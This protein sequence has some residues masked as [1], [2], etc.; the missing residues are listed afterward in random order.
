MYIAISDAN[1]LTN[2]YIPFTESPTFIENIL[3]PQIVPGGTTA[4]F[5]CI[6]RGS[7]LPQIAW[8]HRGNA[9]DEE[10]DKY[11]ISEGED[12]S[13]ATK[14]STLIIRSP[15]TGASG[16]VKCIASV[17]L[18]ADTGPFSFE[19]SS[20]ATHLTV[21]GNTITIIVFYVLD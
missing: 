21:L 16:E 1:Q 20:S 7:P 18:D 3:N 5:N 9:V 19:P 13:N 17:P 11:M 2:E 12:N 15:D 6:V 10:N 8:T 4:V 14:S